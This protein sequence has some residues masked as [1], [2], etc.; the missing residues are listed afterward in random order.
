M[1]TV[2]EAFDRVLQNSVALKLLVPDLAKN[3]NAVERFRREAKISLQLSDE[4]IIRVYDMNIV[5]DTLYISME[6]IDGMNLRELFETRSKNN[7]PLSIEE[8]LSRSSCRGNQPGR[9]RGWVTAW[10][11]WSKKSKKGQ[12]LERRIRMT[13]VRT[14][15][16]ATT[17][18]KRLLQVQGCL[19]F[20]RPMLFK[21]RLWR[22]CGI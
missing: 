15:T 21:N 8:V 10:Q 3:E 18:I 20:R 6:Y 22:F 17:L 9:S 7:K 11:T 12:L 2:Y 1:G 5:D 13:R 19:R 4:R 14:T 16:S